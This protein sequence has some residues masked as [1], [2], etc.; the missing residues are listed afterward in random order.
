MVDDQTCV[1]GWIENQTFQAYTAIQSLDPMEVSTLAIAV[2]V[3]F[4]GGGGHLGNHC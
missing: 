3:F 1:F 4:G 2:G